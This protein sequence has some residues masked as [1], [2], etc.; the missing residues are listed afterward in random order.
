MKDHECEYCETSKESKDK[1][2]EIGH[3]SLNQLQYKKKNTISNIINQ[4]QCNL[5]KALNFYGKD[6][7][8]T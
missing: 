4:N 3:G 6:N 2:N 5:V 1:S 8:T 7:M